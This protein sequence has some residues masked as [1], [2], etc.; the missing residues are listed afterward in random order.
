MIR[1]LL[2]GVLATKTGTRETSLEIKTPV[3]IEGLTE[4]LRKRLPSLPEG[5]FLFAIN[6]EQASKKSI[7]HDGDT[8]AVMPP[9]SGG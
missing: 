7:V 1:V 3:T 6:E 9:F 4:E 5:D 2:F 8:V